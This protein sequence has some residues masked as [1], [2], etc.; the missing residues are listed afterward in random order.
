MLPKPP[1]PIHA[2]VWRRTHGCIDSTVGIDSIACELCGDEP[3]D[4][5]Y[6]IQT[7]AALTRLHRMSVNFVGHDEYM[8]PPSTPRSA[9]LP[10]TALRQ[11]TSLQLFSRSLLVDLDIMVSV[12]Q[13]CWH[14]ISN[15]SDLS[16]ATSLFTLLNK[17]TLSLLVCRPH[18]FY[19]FVPLPA[20]L[21]R[22][23]ARHLSA[24]ARVV[25]GR[26]WSGRRRCTAGGGVAAAAAVALDMIGRACM[27]VCLGCKVVVQAATA[28]SLRNVIAGLSLPLLL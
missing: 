8:P 16:D 13:R 3:S 10:L 26:E 7:L 11:L 12:W 17:V 27:R 18:C 4:V 24:A 15:P 6:T 28:S 22:T 14:A 2:C 9:W 25:L 19:A 1:E 23:A 21:S 20:G 5:Q